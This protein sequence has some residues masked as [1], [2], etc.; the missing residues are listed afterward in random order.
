MFESW[1]GLSNFPMTPETVQ[2]G[3]LMGVQR[4]KAAS[5][6]RNFRDSSE[7]R[8]VLAVMGWPPTSVPPV[9]VCGLPDAIRNPTS[10][11]SII[12]AVTPKRRRDR[13]R[14]RLRLGVT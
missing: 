8:S 14:L 13:N 7:P 4:A 11:S 5:T 9:T 10:K 1:K 3:L 2:Y 6:H 12:E